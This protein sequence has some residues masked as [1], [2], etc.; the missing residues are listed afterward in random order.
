MPEK[1]DDVFTLDFTRDVWFVSWRCQNSINT[2]DGVWWN[3][4]DEIEQ[5]VAALRSVFKTD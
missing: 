1:G 2:F 4:I 5:V 3:N